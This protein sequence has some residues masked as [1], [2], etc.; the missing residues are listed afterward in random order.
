MDHIDPDRCRPD[1]TPYCMPATLTVEWHPSNALFQLFSDGPP[2]EA[3]CG[4][5]NA[6]L[7]TEL[8]NNLEMSIGRPASIAIFGT[9]V[10]YIVGS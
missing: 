6:D 2:Y 4:S 7:Y 9:Y 5:H 1:R 8:V 10:S 3:S